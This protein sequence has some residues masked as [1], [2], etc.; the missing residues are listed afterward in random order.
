MLKY[1]DYCG[2][3]FETANTRRLYCCAACR[4]N[5]DNERKA[6]RR[7]EEA[8]LRAEY[9]MPDDWALHDLGEDVIENSLTDGWTSACELCADEAIAGPMACQQC[10]HWK[11]Q[12]KGRKRKGSAGIDLL[13]AMCR[14]GCRV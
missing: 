11:A 7:E 9:D 12:Q 4:R 2:T 14:D 13:C 6:D 3:A 5:A 10:P 8:G 1:C